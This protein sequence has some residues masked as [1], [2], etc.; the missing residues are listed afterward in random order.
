MR[1]YVLLRIK[2]RKFQENTKKKTE[3]DYVSIEVQLVICKS[4]YHFHKGNSNNVDGDQLQIV[5]PQT[6]SN[7]TPAYDNSTDDIPESQIA[8]RTQTHPD[9][10][11]RV[12]WDIE[13][14]LVQ[15]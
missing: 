1:R 11:D 13:V 2:S 12:M 10:V 6:T 9:P 15:R 7:Q 4:H 3:I 5:V 8:D 14:I